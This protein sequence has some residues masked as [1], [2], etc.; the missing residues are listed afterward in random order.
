MLILSVLYSSPL[1]NGTAMLTHSLILGYLYNLSKIYQPYKASF[2][3]CI[4]IC[5]VCYTISITLCVKSLTI[6]I[7]IL[8]ATSNHCYICPIY[9]IIHINLHIRHIIRRN[10]LNYAEIKYNDIANGPGVRTS[11]F[12]S[13]CTHH[14]KGCFNEIAWDFN[15]GTP[16][17]DATISDIINSMKPDYIAGLTLL[18]GEPFEPANQ[19][20]LIPLL[21]AVKENY[22]A[23]DIW[24][25]TGYLLMR[26]L[27]IKCM[28][29]I[30][31]PEKCFHIL[32]YASMEDLL[33]N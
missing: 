2:L 1:A 21:K 23:K 29:N 17:T 22:P 13:G 26:I 8:I 11:I 24:C 9:D 16:F 4:Y 30:L 6:V 10:I 5:S 12:V 19:R 20:G 7:I 3:L 32:T 18:G 33:K 28:T 25:F 14:C 31:K 27:W 15:Y